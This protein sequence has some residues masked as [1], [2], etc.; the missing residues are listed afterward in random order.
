MPSFPKLRDR[1]RFSDS[2]IA[3]DERAAAQVVGVSQNYTA[4]DDPQEKCIAAYGVGPLIGNTIWRHLRDLTR[5]SA[6]YLFAQYVKV[7]S[8]SSNAFRH[9]HCVG[10]KMRKMRQYCENTFCVSNSRRGLSSSWQDMFR[11]RAPPL[12]SKQMSRA[13]L[14]TYLEHCLTRSTTP[15]PGT[16]RHT[17]P[18]TTS[19]SFDV[20]SLLFDSKNSYKK[21]LREEKNRALL[22]KLCDPRMPDNQRRSVGDY[23]SARDVRSAGVSSSH[24]T[25]I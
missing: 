4:R 2:W 14:S 16:A 19:I 21:S 17:T 8:D 18:L 6:I 3:H 1:N 7:E 10:E 9:P 23:S 11:Y 15:A 25:V 5:A 22:C 12:M 13:C 20:A 24:L